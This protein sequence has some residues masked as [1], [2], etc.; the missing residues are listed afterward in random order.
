M[1]KY[2]VLSILCLSLH[3]MC[4]RAHHSFVS[5]YTGTTALIEGTVT[6]IDWVNPHVLIYMDPNKPNGK[7]TSWIFEMNSPAELTRL[8][9]ERSLISV[10]EKVRIKYFLARDRSP[11]GAVATV[12]LKS[13]KSLAGR[14][15][16]SVD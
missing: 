11:R 2:V 1:K 9:W 14:F 4:V 8:G 6:R 13:G 10:G 3:E 7:P 15:G 16:V 12:T 5:V